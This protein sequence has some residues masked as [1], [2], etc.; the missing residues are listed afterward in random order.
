M[1]RRASWAVDA[2]AL[3]GPRAHAMSVDV[4]EHFQ[5]SA[6]APVVKRTDWDRHPSRVAANTRRVLELF[7]RHGVRATFFT[8]G[9]VAARHPNLVR[10]IVAAGHELASHGSLHQRVHTLSPAEFRADVGDSKR[11][12]EDVAGVAVTGYRAP[13]F[14]IDARTP[15]A[16]EV[17][18][19]EGYRYSSSVFPLSTDHYGMPEAPRFAY[20]PFDD[21]GFLEIPLTTAEVAGRRVPC[22]G[23]GY[24][25]LLPVGLSTRAMRRVTDRDREAC[26]FYFHPWEVD[27]D[28]PRVTGLSA[29]ARFRHYLNLKRMQPRLE[30]LCRSFA[31]DRMDR[32][33][34]VD[35]A[36]ATTARA[37]LAPAL[38]A[39]S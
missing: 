9:W 24:F 15:W 10:D 4:E 18:R 16:H 23:G 8:L 25:R 14:S 1:S 30:V 22:A 32:V 39:A 21:D 29:R 28:Q 35:R 38:E 37:A 31:W 36:S 6:M 34:P 17:L 33:F 7:D 11:L 26:V 3:A 2:T 5:V 20:R 27:P 12:L 19:A 13:S